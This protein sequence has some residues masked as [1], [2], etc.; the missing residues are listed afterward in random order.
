MAGLF[1]DMSRLKASLMPLH[2][3]LGNPL[4]V[5]VTVT[6]GTQSITFTALK[7]E[8]TYKDSMWLQSAGIRVN[9]EQISLTDI[10]AH[11]YG[12][13]MRGGTYSFEGSNYRLLNLYESGSV[14]YRAI[15]E[16]QRLR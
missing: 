1:E 16:K 8:I 11:L 12:D 15:V 4:A 10:P 3:T 5:Q 14:S 2:T 9:N 6:K 13:I 7:N